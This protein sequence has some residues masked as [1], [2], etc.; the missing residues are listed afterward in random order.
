[1]DFIFNP[2]SVWTVATKYLACGTS[3]PQREEHDC[4][5]ITQLYIYLKVS[6]QAWAWLTVM[7][8]TFFHYEK[9][10]IRVKIDCLIPSAVIVQNLQLYVTF[11]WK[12]DG[13]SMVL[14]CSLVRKFISNIFKLKVVHYFWKFPWSDLPRTPQPILLLCF[15]TQKY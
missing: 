1:M 6:L 13:L 12:Y 3:Q 10:S 5:F 2:V 14:S 15:Y 7:L 8:A 9:Q 4:S 11:I